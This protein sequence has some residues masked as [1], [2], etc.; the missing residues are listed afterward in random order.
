MKNRQ[1]ILFVITLALIGGTALLLSHLRA[2][3]HLGKPG[4]QAEPI[5]GTLRMKIELPKHVLDFTSTNVPEPDVVVGYLPKDTSYVEQRYWSPDSAY[6][7]EATVVLMGA[8]RTSIHNADFC[9]RGQGLNPEKKM[10]VNVPI[11][12]PAP[13]QLPVSRWHVSAIRQQPD[14]QKVRL[15]GVYVFWFVADGEQT[16]DHFEMVK[17]LAI[18]LLRTGELQRWTYVSYQMQCQ[19]GEE[20][21]AFDRIAKVIAASVPQFQLPAKS[22]GATAIASHP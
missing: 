21:A 13:Y 10:V 19:P 9:I 14:G 22:V 1:S 2:H 8:D 7:I 18:H 16:P 17:R 3:P 5:P 11:E 4:I 12:S 6:P 20:D 15:T